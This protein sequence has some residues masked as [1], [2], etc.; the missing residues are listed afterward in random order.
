[1]LE[2]KKNLFFP[3]TVRA[4]RDFEKIARK[5]WPNCGAGIKDLSSKQKKKSIVHC[6]G[7]FQSGGNDDR[8]GP[9][10]LSFYL[11]GLTTSGALGYI[12]RCSVSLL[13]WSTPI[14]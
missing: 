7:I 3:A 14:S 11:G 4:S 8:D 1:M 2:T 10:K 13:Y 12:D 6:K 9:T 5:Q